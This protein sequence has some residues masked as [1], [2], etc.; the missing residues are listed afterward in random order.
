MGYEKK[1]NGKLTGR[2]GLIIPLKA[3]TSTL[4][5]LLANVPPPKVGGSAGVGYAIS[6]N[7][8]FDFA[9]FGDPMRS[10]IEKKITLSVTASLRCRF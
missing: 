3:W 1:I 4:G 9:L 6:K 8:D 5:N 7:A 2:M 10:Y